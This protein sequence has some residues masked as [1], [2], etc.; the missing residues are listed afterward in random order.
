MNA[1][2]ICTPVRS[3]HTPRVSPAAAIVLSTPDDL[4]RHTLA[5]FKDDVEPH[6]GAEGPGIV[7]DLAA[8]NF[9]NSTGLGYIVHVGK[10]LAEQGRRLAL[11][12][13][14]R[15]VDKLI[16]MIGL[17]QVLPLFKTLPEAAQ[18]VESGAR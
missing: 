13:P 6:V 3:C 8:L 11:A 4:N 9:V 17:N 15:S 5:G 12:R 7:L 14:S 1:A 2:C 16:R 10:R 18:H